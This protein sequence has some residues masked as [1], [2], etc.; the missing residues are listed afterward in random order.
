M[1]DAVEAGAL[2]VPAVAAVR[3]GEAELERVVAGAFDAH[4]PRLKG[5]ALKATRDPALSDD[6]VQETFVRL[7][8]ELRAGRV[9][10]N[11][12]AWLFRVCANLITSRGR[13]GAV[14][15]RARALLVRRD[16]APSPEDHALRHEETDRLTAGLARLP[17]QARVVLLLAAAGLDA[18]EIGAAVGKTSGA[19]RTYLCRARLQ[20]RDVLAEIDR[21]VE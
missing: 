14:A 9:P 11:L 17:A 20:L 2:T 21:A 4:A 15:E 6:L 1:I 18:A 3:A 16:L 5:F 19:T 10:E 7:V 13:R 8:R 12:Q